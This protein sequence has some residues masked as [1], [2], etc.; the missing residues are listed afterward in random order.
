MARDA[1]DDAYMAR[2][3]RD[4]A[5]GVYG[6]TTLPA[7]PPLHHYTVVMGVVD[8]AGAVF[9]SRPYY[10]VAS[11]F[12]RAVA[13]AWDS[14]ESDYGSGY[15]VPWP[16]SVDGKDVDAEANWPAIRSDADDAEWEAA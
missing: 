6:P 15:I 11:T 3:E 9:H 7:E 10:I 4:Y 1:E 16:V 5:R 14:A 8:L 2:T 12:D 13:K